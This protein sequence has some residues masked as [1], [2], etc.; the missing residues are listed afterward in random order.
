MAPK[1][2]CICICSYKRPHL[3][4]CT[5]ENLRKLETAGLFDYSI[6]VADNDREESAKATVA[7]FARTT[8]LAV[9][10]CMEPE[11]NISLARNKAL[12]FAQGD[13][14][15]WIDDDEYPAANWLL[16]F[17][18][19]LQ[20]YQADG[21]LGPV[22][23][24]FENPPPAWI[25]R[26]RFFDKPR[27]VTGLKLRW[28]QTSTANVLVKRQILHGLAEPFRRQ[29]GSGCED[30]DFFKRMMEAGHA[31]V[32]C[33]EA[34]VSEIIP[35]A[36]WKRRY[37]YRRAFLRGR[38]GKYFAD[39]G[40]VLKSIIA[41]PLYLLLLPFLLLAGQHLFVR[42]LMKIGDH[43]GNLAGIFGL[44]FGGDKYL[45]G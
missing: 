42:Y 24:V 34:I 8:S 33:D 3:L 22:K 39:L 36:R 35:P 17:F 7:E 2:I 15:A 13:F 4:K 20:K 44:K 14:I 21:V 27:R 43:A 29:F 45:A 9:V 25:T 38:N 32:W 37:L 30:L 11:Q 18:E 5:L 31:F 26:G 40:S 41:L 6:V 10:Y 12:E 16:S 28:H 1:H 19:T 23:P